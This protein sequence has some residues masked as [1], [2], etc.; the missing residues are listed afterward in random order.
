M[1]SAS[2]FRSRA[3]SQVRKSAPLSVVGVHVRWQRRLEAEAGAEVENYRMI[4][5]QLE[6]D[7]QSSRERIASLDAES[8]RL[9]GELRAREAAS[10]A[11]AASQGGRTAAD[12]GVVVSVGL[13]GGY[14]VRR[15]YGTPVDPMPYL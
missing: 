10:A 2:C 15:S 11:A 9:E 7:G 8:R 14:G 5:A 12:D 13:R 4:L 1:K 3:D 6:S